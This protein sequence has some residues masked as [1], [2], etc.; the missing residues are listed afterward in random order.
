MHFFA[1]FRAFLLKDGYFPFLFPFLFFFRQ[2]RKGNYHI[3]TTKRT[4]ITPL[5]YIYTYIYAGG[6]FF[7]EVVYMYSGFPLKSQEENPNTPTPHPSGSCCCFF[8]KRKPSFK[9]GASPSCL[10]EEKNF[11]FSLFSNSPF[12]AL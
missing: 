1:I 10:K 11:F 2:K 4:N 3:F 8:E 9:R 12:F 7:V 5:A 6:G